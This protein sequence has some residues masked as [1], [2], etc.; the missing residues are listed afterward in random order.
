MR[1]LRSKGQSPRFWWLVL[2][3]GLISGLLFVQAASAHAMLVRSDPPDHA[4]L[5]Q[6]PTQVRLWFS[7]EVDLNIS[8]LHLLDQNGMDV[9]A[10]VLESDASQPTLVIGDLPKIGTGVYTV[11]YDVISRVD[12]H[13]NQGSIVFGV[14]MQVAGGNVQPGMEI[15]QGLTM[16]EIYG[17]ILRWLNYVALACLV[18]V[19]VVSLMVL[20]PSV[21]SRHDDLEIR[22]LQY[23]ARSRVLAWGVIISLL[24]FILS[25]GL[26]VW[27]AKDILESMPGGTSFVE[28]SRRL[29]THNRLG[30]LW[31]IRQGLV[32]LIAI[33]TWLAYRTGFRVTPIGPEVELF[34]TLEAKR[35]RWFLISGGILT[36]GLMIM[37]S[38][39][40]HAATVKPN[41]ALAIALDSIHL[42]AVGAWLGGLLSLRIGLSP[43]IL[44]RR[45]DFDRLTRATW[46]PF[47]VV[48]LLSVGTLFATGLYATG[49][50]VAS[51]DAM[52]TTP[53]GRLLIG[54]ILLFLLVGFFGLI[55]SMLLH[56]HVFAPLWRLLR[57]PAGWTP[58]ALSRMPV[59]TVAEASIGVVVLFI[60]GYLVA[61]PTANGPEYR[62]AG[63]QQPSPVTQTAGDL[64]ISF[65]A[66]PNMPGA[67]TFTMQVAGSKGAA[68]ANIARVI[69][70]F[71]YQGAS[72]GET[73]ADAFQ[74]EPGVYQLQGDQFSMVGPWGVDV[75]VRRLGIPDSTVHF[76]WVVPPMEQTK[77]VSNADWQPVLT[78]L[79]VI[80]LV[81]LL[82]SAGG[83]FFLGRGFRQIQAHKTH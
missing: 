76:N 9:G 67:N 16:S 24:A 20:S 53:Y 62:Y 13:K 35:V 49:E 5:A 71:K 44:G 42:L 10:V 50:Q 70:R 18:G 25:T 54:K 82:L 31:L 46:S 81:I 43:L 21:L 33:I 39:T 59:V 77:L 37:Q 80:V 83:L 63:S 58:L 38:L 12:G 56:P 17:I 28:V 8:N 27:Q 15:R 48:A 23:H 66:Q 78:T 29:L 57:R 6:P 74:T 14:S 32:I 55:N 61:N 26:L 64:S 47:S 34:K 69:L 3:V 41:P 2:A 1:N 75:V 36:I 60:V 19:F 79:G 52:L 51:L 40:S 22:S 30:A 4:T 65:S 72:M 7:E 68:S 73:T 45:E 11:A